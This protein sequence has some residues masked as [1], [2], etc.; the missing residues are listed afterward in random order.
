MIGHEI[1][2]SFDD[3]G[4]QFDAEGRLLNW[5]TPEDFAHFN[6]A[7]DRLAAQFDKYEPLPGLHVNGKLTLSENI[8][9]VAGLS[10]AYDGY[11]SAYGGKPAPSA[12]GLTGDQ[13]FFLA[14]AQGWRTQVAP[15]GAAQLAHDRRARA[16]RVPRRHGAQPRRLVHGVRREAGREAVPRAEG[17]GAGVVSFCV[18]C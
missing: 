8:A 16:R 18:F 5:W 7:A 17:E 1:S 11:R 12:G 3:Q 4:S 15:R 14:F 2:H 10:A 13:R 6:A 9:D